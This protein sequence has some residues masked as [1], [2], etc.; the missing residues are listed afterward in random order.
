MESTHTEPQSRARIVTTIALTDAKELDAFCK[1][2]PVFG[3][4]IKIKE[5]HAPENIC[6]IEMNFRSQTKPMF[7][8]TLIHFFLSFANEKYYRINQKLIG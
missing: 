1:R 6:S 5:S 8:Q 3:V 2:N 7:H 4:S